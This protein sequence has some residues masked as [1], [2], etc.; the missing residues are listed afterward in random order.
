ASC[1]QRF[2]S[3]LSHAVGKALDIQS[4]APIISTIFTEIEDKIG[5]KSVKKALTDALT[6][7]FITPAKNALQA[8][9]TLQ[10]KSAKTA[11]ALLKK[12]ETV[13]QSSQE[14]FE[15][16]REKSIFSEKVPEAV[17]SFAKILK[18]APLQSESS[19][20]KKKTTDQQTTTKPEKKAQKA[21]RKQKKQTKKS[22]NV[23]LQAVQEQRPDDKIDKL[24]SQIIDS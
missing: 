15:K 24:L 3:P 23:P 10:K 8:Y 5:D 17:T 4:D 1:Y 21:S 16:I 20:T 7:N 19:K 22:K 12:N 11:D 13:L 18:Q 2:V 6:K 14:M 9:K